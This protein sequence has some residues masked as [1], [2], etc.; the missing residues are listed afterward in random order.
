MRTRPSIDDIL[1]H[2]YDNITTGVRDVRDIINSPY[3]T[4][5]GD[6]VRLVQTSGI[7]T[8]HGF[9][10]ERE[11]KKFTILNNLTLFHANTQSMF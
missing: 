3:Y 9:L 1:T 6:F 5:K 11:A 7:E 2:N 8:T 4:N 10:S